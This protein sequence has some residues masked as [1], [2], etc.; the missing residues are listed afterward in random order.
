MQFKQQA[1]LF[2]SSAHSDAL[3]LELTRR[4]IPLVN[5]AA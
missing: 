4:N 1:V 5:S 3:E 2:R